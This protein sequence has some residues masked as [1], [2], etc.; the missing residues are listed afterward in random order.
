MA[1]SREDSPVD[2]GGEWG[3]TGHSGRHELQA[4]ENQEPQR[5]RNF[6]PFSLTIPLSP[7]SPAFA[8]HTPSLLSQTHFPYDRQTR[9]LVWLGCGEWPF[10]VFSIKCFIFTCHPIAL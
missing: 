9:E 5:H 1:G 10:I 6:V 2:G 4:A 8:H 3:T 7:F